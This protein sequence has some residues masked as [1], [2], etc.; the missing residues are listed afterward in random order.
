VTIIDLSGESAIITGGGS[1]IGLAIARAF[2]SCGAKVTLVGRRESVLSTAAH[3]LGPMAST[4]V[5]DITDP[6]AAASI[7]REAT[8]LMGG[9]ASVLVNNAGV[10]KKLSATETSYEE[11]SSVLMTHV[12]AAFALAG[13]VLPNM[14]N[15]RRG[16]ILF[17]SSMAALFG[18]PT[19][20][21]YSAAKAAYTGL[22]YQLAVDYGP[23][24][25]R[26]NAIA[27]GWVRT[28]MFEKAM[29]GDRDRLERVI[30]RTPLGRLGTVDEI[31]N[32]AA[33]LCSPLSSFVT[34][35]LVRVDGGAAIGF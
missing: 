15:Q 35:S 17:V 10:Q 9:A 34:G 28:E 14:V 7:V 2:V 20:P 18:I 16:S 29:T 6:G 8:S 24:G 23:S 33:F 13:A 19:I 4:V 27:P 5:Q 26:V 21:A 32:V 25:V 11:F 30:A 1:G 31:A 12:G 3:E 22:V